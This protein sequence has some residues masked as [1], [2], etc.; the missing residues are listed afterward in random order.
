MPDN[1]NQDTRNHTEEILNRIRTGSA[2]TDSRG[3][4]ITLPDPQPA[5]SPRSTPLARPSSYKKGGT[6]RKTGLAKL[7]KGE[8]LLTKKKAL[9]LKAKLRKKRKPTKKQIG[10]RLT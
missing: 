2:L 3:R 10:K 4:R 7:H 1:L 5:I 8:V 9:A 6:V